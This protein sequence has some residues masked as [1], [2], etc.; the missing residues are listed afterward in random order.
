MSSCCTGSC[1]V[2]GT[3]ENHI[4]NLMTQLVEEN[5]SLWR[6]QKY[7]QEDSA[8]CA[9]CAKL[10]EAMINDKQSHIKTMEALLK[11]TLR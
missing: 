7:Y 6:I 9:D 11:K 1:S 10:W 8:E 3:T 5:R 4:Y 2:K